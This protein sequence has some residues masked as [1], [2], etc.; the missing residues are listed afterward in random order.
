MTYGKDLFPPA[1]ISEEDAEKYVLAAPSYTDLVYRM[2]EVLD[3]RYDK[4]LFGGPD[5]STMDVSRFKGQME[6]V[7]ALVK[8][9]RWRTLNEIAS[10]CGCSTQSASARLR[11][12]R[13]PRFGSHVVE[14]RRNQA[15]A[16]GIF[17]YRVDPPEGKP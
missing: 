9:G 13:K 6:R 8:D 16:E 14:R 7:L 4:P 17:E 11:D 10:R 2:S 1:P 12:L 5:V 3:S 15:Y